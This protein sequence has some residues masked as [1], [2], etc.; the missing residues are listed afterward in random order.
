MKEVTIAR[1]IVKIKI[2]GIVYI[3]TVI[4]N[5]MKEVIDAQ[6][7]VNKTEKYWKSNAINLMNLYVGDVILLHVE[8]RNA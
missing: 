3:I 7:I 4:S 1:V 2:T 8:A 5:H 6:N